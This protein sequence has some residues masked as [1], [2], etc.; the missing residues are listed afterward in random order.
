VKISLHF[1]KVNEPSKSLFLRIFTSSSQL[2]KSFCNV[3]KKA[4]NVINKTTLIGS[5]IG[6]TYELFFLLSTASA[7]LDTFCFLIGLVL[8]IIVYTFC[9][10]IYRYRAGIRIKWDF[11]GLNGIDFLGFIGLKS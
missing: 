7:D 4:R 10:E 9:L 6:K 2:T 5:Q 8:D 1:E 3:G 11:W